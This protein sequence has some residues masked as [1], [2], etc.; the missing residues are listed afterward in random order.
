MK[1]YGTTLPSNNDLIVVCKASRVNQVLNYLKRK[2]PDKITPTLEFGLTRRARSTPTLGIRI[3]HTQY[4]CT[5]AS[6]TFYDAD[7]PD[8]ARVYPPEDKP[9]TT[10][11][12][13]LEV[14]LKEHR[15]WAEFNRH[16]DDLIQLFPPKSYLR[17]GVRWRATRKGPAYWEELHRKWVQLYDNYKHLLDK[18]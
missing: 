13:L 18:D 2:L 15:S 16:K 11:L 7:Y 12:Q 3:S 5:M 17:A 1:I 14:F 10:S 4:K 8:T 6:M 9:I